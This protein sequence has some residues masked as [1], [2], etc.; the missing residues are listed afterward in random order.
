MTVSLAAIESEGPTI[1][2]RSGG[3]TATIGFANGGD[4]KPFEFTREGK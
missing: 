2:V 1:P 4:Y 3:L